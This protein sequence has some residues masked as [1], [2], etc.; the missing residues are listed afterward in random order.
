[1]DPFLAE[2]SWIAPVVG[3]KISRKTVYKERNDSMKAILWLV[4]LLI[5]SVAAGGCIIIG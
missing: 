5:V 3:G 2:M 1:V 4:L